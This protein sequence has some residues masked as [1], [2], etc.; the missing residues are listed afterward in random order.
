MHTKPSPKKVALLLKHS[1][2]SLLLYAAAILFYFGL[3]PAITKHIAAQRSEEQLAPHMVP[4]ATAVTADEDALNSEAERPRHYE[5]PREAKNSKVPDVISAW[6]TASHELGIR[7]AANKAITH[8]DGATVVFPVHLPD[9]GAR[10]GALLWTGR[11]DDLAI[12]ERVEAV[13]YAWDSATP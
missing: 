10:N 8:P 5:G 7:F 6:Q 9:F 11:L 12:I 2:L 3:I 1:T 13:A 4:E